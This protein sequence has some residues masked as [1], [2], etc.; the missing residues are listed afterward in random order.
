VRRPPLLKYELF[1]VVRLTLRSQRHGLYLRRET[2]SWQRHVGVETLDA[3]VEV[4]RNVPCEIILKARERHFDGDFVL[5]MKFQIR[6]VLLCSTDRGSN[7]PAVGCRRAIELDSSIKTDLAFPLALSVCTLCV[8]IFRYPYWLR[9]RCLHN[10]LRSFGRCAEP[11][12]VL[13]IF[14][15]GSLTAWRLKVHTSSEPNLD[16]LRPT[17]RPRKQ[18][19]VRVGRECLWSS[20]RPYHRFSGSRDDQSD[21]RRNTNWE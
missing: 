5:E 9:M 17:R 15:H 16:V 20:I 21:R 6:S 11:A 13:E 7:G 4:D 19:C 12:Q 1:Q 18:G 8:C 10:L 2:Q 3:R 14:L